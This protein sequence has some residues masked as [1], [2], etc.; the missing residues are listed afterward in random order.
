MIGVAE[1]E[2]VENTN[3]ILPANIKKELMKKRQQ[4]IHYFKIY[5]LEIRLKKGQFGWRS[6]YAI[7]TY[8]GKKWKP[9]LKYYYSDEYREFDS[10]EGLITAIINEITFK[11]SNQL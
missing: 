4:E 11:F 9:L 1:L 8:F 3:M 5:N 10:K 6:E 7:K 2:P